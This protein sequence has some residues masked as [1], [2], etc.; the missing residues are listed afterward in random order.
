MEEYFGVVPCT[1]MSMMSERS[2]SFGLRSGRARHAEHVHAGAGQ[3]DA[4]RAAGLEQ[5]LRQPIPTSACASIAPT[6]PSTSS[7]T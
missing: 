6:C 7:K 2:D 4:V 3:R 1:I 5:Q